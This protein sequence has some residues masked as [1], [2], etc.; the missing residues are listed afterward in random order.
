MSQVFRSRVWC[1]GD[2]INTDLILPNDMLNFPRPQRA[3]SVFRANRPGWAAQVRQGDILIGGRNFGMGSGRPSALAMKDLG[4][5]CMAADSLNALFFRNCVNY[6]L[7]ALEIEG[8]RAAFEEGDEAEVD[9]DAATVTNLRTGRRL[10]GTPWPDMLLKSLRAGGLI[11]R[12]EA[13]GLIHP[14]GWSPPAPSSM[15]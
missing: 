12:L 1:V 7:P 14:A 4:L 5:V 13:D 2:D 6:A 3:Q 15:P 8:V 9:F 11:E 10:V